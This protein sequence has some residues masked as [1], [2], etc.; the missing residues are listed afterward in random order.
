[1]PELAGLDPEKGSPEGLIK[2]KVIEL[3]NEH[4]AKVIFS[5]D[6]ATAS[7]AYDLFVQKAEDAGLSQLE[8]Y[9]SDIYKKNVESKS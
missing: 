6:E 4:I 9:W 1:M 7:A 8:G 5:K 3:A 2:A